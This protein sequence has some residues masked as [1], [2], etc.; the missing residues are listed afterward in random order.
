[1]H[2]IAYREQHIPQV[3]NVI[4]ILLGDNSAYAFA[5]DALQDLA[6]EIDILYEAETLVHRGGP[7]CP[8]LSR[9]LRNA[10]RAPC[11]NQPRRSL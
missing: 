10:L 2:G 9:P 4:P 1:M 5:V 7:A 11:N 8:I 6:C 3:A